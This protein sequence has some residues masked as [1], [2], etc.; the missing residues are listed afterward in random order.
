MAKLTFIYGVVGASKSGEAI[1]RRNELTKK[2]K[3]VLLMKPKIDTRHD[4]REL[5]STQTCLSAP[6]YAFAQNEN[7][8]SFFESENALHKISCV[9][10]DACQFC[11]KK[12]V[13]NL[14]EIATTVPV[15]C[16]GLKTNFQ[17]QLFEGSKRLLEV[18]DEVKEIK[19]LCP[20][21]KK[22]TMTAKFN[23][24]I[25]TVE[26]EEVSIIESRKAYKGLCYDCF[27]RELNKAKIY[28]KIIKYL[29]IFKDK[30]DA[31]TWSSDTTA[32]NWILQPT[33]VIYDEDVQNFMEDFKEFQVKNPEKIM[34]IEDNIESIRKIVV[35]GKSYDFVMTLIS[36]VLKLE[37]I[38]PGLL[39]ALIEDGTICKWL[40]QIKADVDHL[41]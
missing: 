7:L 8:L 25:L 11:T 30:D 37:K 14:R 12:Q 4:E 19:H 22:A 5:V 3:N 33:H 41:E 34:L 2:G 39:K 15:F 13:D 17:T 24:N 18:A 10:V 31:G 40:R 9:I 20:C 23:G 38:R 28:E 6:C 29:K 16:Y 27:R 35:R 36:H 21:G 32:D 26:G 1:K